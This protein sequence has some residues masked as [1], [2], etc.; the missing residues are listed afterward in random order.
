MH[1][2]GSSYEMETYFIYLF[3]MKNLIESITN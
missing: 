2:L 1:Q 3:S